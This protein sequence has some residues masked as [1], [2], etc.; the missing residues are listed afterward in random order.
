MKPM[1]SL[2]VTLNYNTY[3]KEASHLEVYSQRELYELAQG[4]LNDPNITSAVFHV[5]PLRST[6]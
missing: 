4:Y 5:V 6:P 2:V 3:E 1:Y